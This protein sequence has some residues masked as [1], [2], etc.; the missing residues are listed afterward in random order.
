MDQTSVTYSSN[1]FPIT[2]LGEFKSRIEKIFFEKDA[3]KDAT[4]L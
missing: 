1:V 2:S 3:N 4:V